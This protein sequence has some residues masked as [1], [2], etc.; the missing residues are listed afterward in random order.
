MRLVSSGNRFMKFGTNYY[1]TRVI[2]PSEGN[3]GFSF[4]NVSA[5]GR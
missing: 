2:R 3:E 5:T 1:I 4:E